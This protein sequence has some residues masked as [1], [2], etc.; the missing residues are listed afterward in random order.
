MREG[1][2]HAE[3]NGASNDRSEDLASNAGH[4]RLPQFDD[5]RL[6]PSRA[7]RCAAAHL[8]VIGAGRGGI[9]R[10]LQERF[11]AK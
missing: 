8:P 10:F 6:G 1:D 5:W 11:D 3:E 2:P 7:Y 4:V 9:V